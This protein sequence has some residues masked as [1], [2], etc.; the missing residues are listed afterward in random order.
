MIVEERLTVK[1]ATTGEVHVHHSMLCSP[2]FFHILVEAQI[3]DNT[4]DGAELSIFNHLR[5][6]NTQWEIPRPDSLHQEQVLSLCR[7]HQL[8]CLRC[9]HGE[10]FLA[11]NILAG[12]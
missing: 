12:F 3:C 6:V 10:R 2:L 11:K 9:I 7:L 4:V 5:N 1:Q 8:L